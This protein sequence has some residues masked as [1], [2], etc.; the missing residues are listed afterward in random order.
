MAVRISVTVTVAPDAHVRRLL[1]PTGVATP[2]QM[3]LGFAVD[4]AP[5]TLTGEANTGQMA[6]LISPAPGRPLILRY[7]LADGGTAYPEALFTPRASCFTRAADDLVG[8]A[9]RIADAAT[10][11]DEAIAAIVADVAAAFTYGHPES[12]FNDGLDHIPQLACGTAEGSCVDINTYLIAALRAAGF[13][14]GYVTGYFFPAE[15]HGACDDMHCWV[16]IRQSDRVEEWD[17]AHH[18][19]MGAGEI[20]ARLNP[21]PGERVALAHSMGLDFPEAGIGQ[22]K[23]LAEPVWVDSNGRTEKADVTIRMGEG[24]KRPEPA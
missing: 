9:R 3:P 10:D 20:R 15:K 17:I 2:H 21:K 19:K 11:G 7:S 5:F 23:L 13:E 24:A 4:G 6:A 1:A 14:A 8:H 16:V 18:L 22:L 12:R